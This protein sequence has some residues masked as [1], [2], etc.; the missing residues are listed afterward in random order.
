[1]AGKRQAASATAELKAFLTEHPQT[2]SVD[3]M[4]ID[5]SG[6]VR[7]KRYPRQD[8]EKLYTAG[9][10]IP[11]S[12]FLLDVTGESLDPAGR[13]FTDGDPDGTAI[14][15]PGS[16]M[17][18]P[19]AAEPRGQV[20]MTMH[21]EMGRPSIVDPRN[22]AAAVLER[23]A[24]L[25]LTPVVAFELEFYLLDLERGPD[26]RPRPPVSETTGRRQPAG[27]VYAIDRL[28]DFP[29]FFQGIESARE[30]QGI[31]VSVASKEYAAGQFEINLRHRDDALVAADYGA[32]LRHMLKNVALRCG[33]DVSFMSKP[34]LDQTGNGMH[35]HLSLIDKRGRNVFDDGS[36]LGSETLRHA[37][38]GLAATM[39]ESM[40]ILAPN[41]NA[42]RRF[43]PNLFVPV[44]K[45]W[46]GDN[47]S[48][49]FRVPGGPGDA[50]RVEHRPA[51]A[52][53]NPY[54]V[55]AA[56]LA[57][58][59][60]GITQ[61]I[62]P[63]PPWQGNASESVDPDLPMDLPSALRRL[64]EAP[65]LGDY[66]GREYIDIY[67]DAKRLEYEKFLSLITDREYAW[68]L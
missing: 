28:D 24:E 14:P 54:L 16:L 52:D 5:M 60:H 34:F 2:H 7:G 44:T 12:A 45:S 66:I 53:A 8:A 61:K 13:G 22:I 58:V 23:F 30:A 50:R 37:I 47:R 62:D 63:G 21:D 59:H 56:V 4:F 51:G 32:L 57:G 3:A 9:L 20:L 43:G 31:P 27:Q 10:Q 39:A 42:Y 1:M 33:L 49:A 6:I 11:Y 65:V 35:V 36:A 55:L 40:A 29:S 25:G 41:I 46:G 19:W 26:G 67:V 64:A 18:V 68:Y 48:L 38:G 17:P 15:V